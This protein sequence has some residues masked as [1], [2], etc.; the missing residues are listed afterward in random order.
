MQGF[1]KLRLQQWMEKKFKIEPYAWSRKTPAQQAEMLLKLCRGPRPPMEYFVAKNYEFRIPKIAL[2]K[3][4]PGQKRSAPA[5][6][7]TKRP[8]K[9]EQS[10]RKNK[11]SIDDD[12]GFV[13]YEDVEVVSGR[14][15]FSPL[16]ASDIDKLFKTPPPVQPKQQTKNG[17]KRIL[18]TSDSSD[19]DQELESPS[20]PQKRSRL[21]QL[22]SEDVKKLVTPKAKRGGNSRPKRTAKMPK[23]LATPSMKTWG[24]DPT[25]KKYRY[26]SDQ[27]AADHQSAQQLAQPSA[28]PSTQP[29]DQPSAQQP[30]QQPDQPP[31]QNI[32]LST[33]DLERLR[34][35]MENRVHTTLSNMTSQL[36]LQQAP[37]Q[38]VQ[39]NPP[40]IQDGPQNDKKVPAD[41]NFAS[42]QQ[43]FLKE[44]QTSLM[45]YGETAGSPEKTA[46]SIDDEDDDFIPE[47]S[48]SGNTETLKEQLAKASKRLEELKR[49]P[50]SREE[51]ERRLEEREKQIEKKIQQREDL[52][53]LVAKRK[54]S[55]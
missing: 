10:R 55:K 24:Y 41:D 49:T 23:K 45:G 26:L 7:T 18:A 48:F 47:L 11:T 2:V 21:D 34:T 5:E 15:V 16:N 19:S 39:N 29:S 3:K 43:D 40:V 25:K 51:W 9:H 53:K 4:K 13:R 28:Q 31:F 8:Q 32:P 22:S 35:H 33:S 44:A 36:V 52:Q 14:D 27:P 42:V 54:G 1:G 50:R 20:V 12:S 37:Q 46:I 30:D 38:T 6:R 17:R